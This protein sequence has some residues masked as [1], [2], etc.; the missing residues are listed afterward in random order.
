MPIFAQQFIGWASWS[1]VGLIAMIINS[2][3]CVKEYKNRKSRE[4]FFV[5][6][7]SQLSSILCIS[8]GTLFGCSIFV[9]Y[10]QGF[11][12][13]GNQLGLI[14]Y[15]MGFSFMGF[16][17]LAR[18]YYCFSQN[19]VYSTHGY[20]NCLF[21]IMGSIGIVII[22]NAII[23][24]WFLVKIPIHCGINEE[25]QYFS[26]YSDYQ[27]DP[28]VYFWGVITVFIHV[29][30]DFVTLLLYIIKVAAFRK[31]KTKNIHIYNRTMSILMR[32]LILTVFYEIM[33][34]IVLVIWLSGNQGI[35]AH[36][37]YGVSVG[38]ASV[39]ISYSMFLM[40]Q[41]NTSPEYHI[42]LTVCCSC[43]KLSENVDDNQNQNDNKN[44]NEQNDIS[45]QN[46]KEIPV[47]TE[48]SKINE[49]SIETELQNKT[50]GISSLNSGL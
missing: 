49:L 18:I 5:S 48:H 40:Q 2:L 44:Q 38:S 35:V 13:F 11:C 9:Q 46:T 24:P 1:I 21:I 6:K 32:V 26:K 43:C 28:F 7:L 34:F 42:F 25:A 45:I 31:Y 41:H 15:Y 14:F 17:Q 20:S 3:I 22:L 10:F 33:T 30:W 37:L 47:K 36:I 29:S 23:Y 16:Y 12:Y 8:C 4:V 50:V 19:K 39:C 27:Q